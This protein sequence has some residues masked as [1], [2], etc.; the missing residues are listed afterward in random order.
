ML[1]RVHDEK[2]SRRSNSEKKART[3]RHEKKRLLQI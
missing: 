3:I 1:Y 2:N